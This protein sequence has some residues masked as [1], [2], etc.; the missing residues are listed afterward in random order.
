MEQY[1]GF[2]LGDAESAIARLKKENPAETEILSVRSAKSFVSAYARRNNGEVLIGEQACFV[3]DA[4][5]RK[6]RF[7][8]RFLTDPSAAKDIRAFAAGVLGALR[9]N[10]DLI[11]GA[12]DCFYIGCPAGW[13]KNDRE[14]YREIFEQ[15]GYPPARIVSESRAALVWAC[16]SKHLQVG[17]DILSRPVLVVDIGSST[18][19]FAYITEGKEAALHTAGEVFLGGGVM[20]ELLLEIAVSNSEHQDRIRSV[21][22]ASP[23]WQSYCEF[24]ARRLK[25]Q[26]F[27]DEEYWSAPENPCEKTIL[28]RYDT[29]VRLKLSIDPRIAA[30]LLDAPSPAL[31]GRSFK[32]VFEGSLQQVRSAIDGP[33]PD[34][35]FLTGGVSRL[36]AIRTWC[37]SAF[38]EAVV[39]TGA[40]PEF[41]VAMGLAQCGKIDEEVRAF[42][43]DVAELISSPFIEQ[44]VSEH[45][46]DLY[47]MSA[48]AL[49][50]PILENAALPVFDRWRS[51]QI[52]RLGDVDDILQQE[53]TAWLHTEQARAILVEPVTAWLKPVAYDLEEYTMPICARHNVPYAALN[54]N[55]YLSVSDIDIQVDARDV[56][57]V[58]EITWLIDAIISVLV[59]LLCGGSGVALLTGGL[60]GIVTG[61]FISL[62][63]LLLGKDT[64]QKA[65]LK[66][67]IPSPMRKLIPK[68]HFRSRLESM[69]GEVK[70]RLAESLSVDKNEEISSRMAE[71]IS[72]QIEECLTKMAEVVEIPLG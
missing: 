71:E 30:M 55:A 40:S 29:P 32:S 54:L 19:D 15:L 35:V 63:I 53:I 6:V 3:P 14:Q 1:F 10:G 31:D 13:D 66:L 33:M 46:A 23:A 18:T 17:Y 22:E 52:R 59:G 69:A 24:A 20:D 16:Q 65:V 26:Y 28:L 50:T 47:R 5:V 67:D 38:P 21:F 9:E 25:E 68:N 34:L 27:S 49:V 45:L 62:L 56:F 42:K 2:D 39:I 70:L 61:A 64:M 41:A 57:A 72:S 60:P 11:A 7:K 48:E 36:P 4:A 37:R 12:D 44:I 51:R 58:D 43:K 8:S